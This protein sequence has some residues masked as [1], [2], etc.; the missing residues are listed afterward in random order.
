MRREEQEGGNDKLWQAVRR[1]RDHYRTG[2]S[3]L[4]TKEKMSTQAM[5]VD[6]TMV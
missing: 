4:N 1:R 5:M 3:S 6:L 2:F